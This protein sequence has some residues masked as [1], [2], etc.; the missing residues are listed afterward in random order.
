MD[1]IIYIKKIPDVTMYACLAG[2]L[3][4]FMVIVLN[5]YDAISLIFQNSS[6]QKLVVLTETH[7]EFPAQS[8]HWFTSPTPDII[9]PW[10][11]ITK[12]HL[13]NYS[14]GGRRKTR[15]RKLYFYTSKGKVA[16]INSRHINVSMLEFFTLVRKFYTGEILQEYRW[17]VFQVL[18]ETSDGQYEWGNTVV[19]V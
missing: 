19:P 17:G 8:G 14:T 9:I 3:F 1:D 5:G 12:I 18:K 16:Q 13:E 6:K 4:G 10:D 15:H 7:I 2:I 11:K